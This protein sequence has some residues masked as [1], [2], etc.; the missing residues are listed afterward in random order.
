MRSTKYFDTVQLQSFNDAQVEFIAS[1][2][3]DYQDLGLGNLQ[4]DYAD[5]LAERA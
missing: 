5:E 4:A 3:D 1:V 2:E